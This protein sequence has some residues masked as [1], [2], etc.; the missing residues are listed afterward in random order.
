MVSVSHRLCSLPLEPHSRLYSRCTIPKHTSHFPTPQLSFMWKPHNR[1]FAIWIWTAPLSGTPIIS[2]RLC[3][4]A[5]E[6]R[7]TLY[8]RYT[9]RKT[10]K[11]LHHPMGSLT[12]KSHYRAS[13]VWI[14][15]LPWQRAPYLTHRLCTHQRDFRSGLCSGCTIPKTHK[16]LHHPMHWD[17]SCSNRI[18]VHQLYGYV[19]PLGC[20]R[21]TSAMRSVHIL[22]S[23]VAHYRVCVRS[24]KRASHFTTP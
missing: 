16:P 9:I 19:Q 3:T 2:R 8:S 5:V 22:G 11:P 7:N 1:P 17:H 13:V 10:Y 12:C 14:C 6:T 18:M 21:P 24:R 20:G 23:P 15:T 4:H